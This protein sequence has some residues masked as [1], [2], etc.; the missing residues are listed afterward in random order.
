MNYNILENKYALLNLKPKYSFV[1]V[2]SILLF[3]LIIFFSI[4]YKTY[5]SFK[6]TGTY[7]N[8]QISITL[9]S[10]DTKNIIESD[11]LK[12]KNQKYKFSIQSISQAEYEVITN[13]SYQ[14]VALSTSG[15]FFDN[16]ILEITFYKNKQRIISKIFN[17][18]K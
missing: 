13:T 17:L 4:Y 8:N 7:L 15:S 2:F 10:S 1:I 5:D 6:V 18:L 11:Y 14:K 12:I 9:L 16:E 3:L